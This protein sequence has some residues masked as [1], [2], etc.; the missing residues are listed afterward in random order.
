MFLKYRSSISLVA[1]ITTGLI[2]MFLLPSKAEAGFDANNI[3]SDGTFVDTTRMDASAVQRFLDSKGGFLA[4]FSENGRSAAQ[5]IVDAARGRYDAAGSINGITINESTGTINPQAIMVTLQKEQSLITMTSQND[6]AL[7]TAMGYGCPDSGGCN[8]AY[9]GF[10][11]QVE[12]G[13]WQ[14]RYNYERAQGRGFSDYQVGQGF[15]FSDWNGTHSGTFGNRATA[16]LYRYTPHVYNG[17]YNFWY[18]FD[19][20]FIQKGFNAQWVGQSAVGYMRIGDTATLEVRFKN[21]GTETWYP[22][23]SNPVI[24]AVDKNWASRTAWQGTGWIS[25]NRMSTAI[26]GIIAPGETGT[27]RFSINCPNGMYPGTHKFYARLVSEGRSWF[28]DPDTNGAAWWLISVPRPTASWAG[29]SGYVTAWPGQEADMTVNFKNTS[30]VAW[31]RSSGVTTTL[32][33]DKLESEQFMTSFRQ[34]SWLSQNRIAPLSQETVANGETATFNF[35]IKIPS[36]LSPGNYR[37][38]VRLV[39]DGF[40]WFENPDI[41]GAAWWGISVPKPTATWVGQS[42]LPLMERGQS[43]DVSLQLRNT[44]GVTWNASG[45][46]GTILA[47]DKFWSDRTAWQGP[48]WINQNRIAIPTGVTVGSGQVATFNFKISVP[49]SMP[50][51]KHKFYARLVAEGFSWFED[52]DTNGAAWWELNVL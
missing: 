6:N 37:F 51:G 25:E 29:Q 50:S 33:T 14:L 15:T 34:S 42:A 46:P 30:G 35:K 41:N 19:Q 40:S 45:A 47:I 49:T 39:Q 9:A 26:E 32:A 27:F 1:A 28:E 2:A 52:P 4:G 16:S 48:G 17:N 3:I 38:N 22:N 10:T 11:K 8:P 18:F 24:L 21:V 5:I 36:N 20:Y 12:N 13:A 31:N 44:S 23:G 7:R 43:Y